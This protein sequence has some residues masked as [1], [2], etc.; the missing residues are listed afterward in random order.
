MASCTGKF[1][2]NSSMDYERCQDLSE[3]AWFESGAQP[4]AAA[5]PVGALDEMLHV[6]DA[7]P[8]H[9][10]ANSN[11]YSL[12]IDLDGP[13]YMTRSDSAEEVKSV[14]APMDVVPMRQH[15]ALQI[16]SLIKTE[17]E[18][19]DVWEPKVDA[20]FLDQDLLS[21]LGDCDLID[22]IVSGVRIPLKKNKTPIISF[23]F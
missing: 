7:Q 16:Q 4:W 13:F 6:K 10:Y 14:T 1:A 12:N 23:V 2:P 3:L 8:G 9:I 11:E 22:Y 20:S 19:I 18:S 21:E 5:E 15:E 17:N